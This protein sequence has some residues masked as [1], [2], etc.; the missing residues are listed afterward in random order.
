MAR[1]EIRRPIDGSVWT[2]RRRR[3]IERR[4]AEKFASTFAIARGDDGRVNVGKAAL[5]EEAVDGHGHPATHAHER[6]ESVRPRPEVRDGPEELH[7]V[8]LFLQRER[9]VGPADQAE[10]R[11]FELPLLPLSR[12]RHEL[13]LN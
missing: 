2:L 4:D 10:S 9:F 1:K 5:L 12:R 6:A 8:P 7:G 11:G 13:A 3:R